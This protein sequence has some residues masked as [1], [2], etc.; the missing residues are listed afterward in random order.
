MLH[1]YFHTNRYAGTVRGVLR[2]FAKFS[3]EFRIGSTLSPRNHVALISH[4]P[5][6][7]K[8]LGFFG[9]QTFRY[10]ISDLVCGCCASN[11]SRESCL[12]R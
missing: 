10:P 1:D 12:D 6:K 8:E 2:V 9:I 5:L 3:C 11:E 4:A 7:L